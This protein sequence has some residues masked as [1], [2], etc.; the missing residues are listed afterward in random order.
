[1]KK[2]SIILMAVA[3]A[4]T[5]ISAKANPAEVECKK[6]ANEAYK[7]AVDSHKAAKKEC[8]TKKGAEKKDCLKSAQTALK[9]A[10][11]AKADALKACK[12][13]PAVPEVPAMP[14]VPSIPG[15]K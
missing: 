3:F 5:G 1:M 7:G 4:A 6:K 13:L 12:S 15:G 9:D 14:A 2:I 11:K 10:Q 8:G